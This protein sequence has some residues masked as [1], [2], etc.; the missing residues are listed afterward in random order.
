MGKMVVLRFTTFWLLLLKTP[1]NA[2]G[3]WTT[4][5]QSQ[6]QVLYTPGIVFGSVSQRTFWDWLRLL[7]ALPQRCFQTHRDSDANQ[8]WISIA[9]YL[10]IY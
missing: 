2:C 3:Y 4:S 1:V 9:N 7:H 5:G 6:V 8:K 10:S